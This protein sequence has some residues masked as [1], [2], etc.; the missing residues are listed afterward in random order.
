MD[1]EAGV[2]LG[3][4]SQKR[5]ESQFLE[6]LVKGRIGGAKMD[7]ARPQRAGLANLFMD[8]IAHGLG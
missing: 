4:M 6:E 2:H 5:T 3:V 1:A 7:R 8:P